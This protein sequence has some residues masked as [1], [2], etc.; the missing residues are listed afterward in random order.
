MPK[1]IAHR[2]DVALIVEAHKRRI[3]IRLKLDVVDFPLAQRSHEPPISPLAAQPP[4]DAGDEH[5]QQPPSS[6]SPKQ[7]PRR[8]LLARPVLLPR[9][10]CR[11]ALAD[12]TTDLAAT[13]HEGLFC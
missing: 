6:D 5:D 12:P 13:H 1:R 7:T 8:A 9:R 3:G 2:V 11:L 10:L 4:R